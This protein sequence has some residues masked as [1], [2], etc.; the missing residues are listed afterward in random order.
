MKHIV[1]LLVFMLAFQSMDVSLALAQ[2]S[3]TTQDATQ[4]VAV[5]ALDR[6]SGDDNGEAEC[7]AALDSGS[8]KIY[9][10]TNLKGKWR[11]PLDNVAHFRVWT[12]R[13]G[14]ALMKIEDGQFHFVPQAENTVFRATREKGLVMIYARDDCGN[15][16]KKIVYPKLKLAVGPPGPAGPQGPKGDKGDPGPP[17]PPGK[18]AVLPEKKGHGK[19]IGALIVGGALIGGGIYANNACLF[20]KCPPGY[21]RR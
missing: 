16:T 18:D 21:Q 11:N 12:P 20:C 5:N 14:C 7:L 9:Q 1:R 17:G 15:E 10:P 13:V 2:T 19:L 4:P 6:F 8:Y 3:A